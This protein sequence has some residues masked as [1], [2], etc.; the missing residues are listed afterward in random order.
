MQDNIT[1]R[2]ITRRQFRELQ[3]DASA[4]TIYRRQKSVDGYPQPV[5]INRRAHYWSDEVDRY[6]SGL[7]KSA[8]AS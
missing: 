5:Y 7:T 4:M 2:L 8:V 1:R 6:L 3:G